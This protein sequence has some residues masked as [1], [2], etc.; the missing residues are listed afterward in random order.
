VGGIGGPSGGEDH[1]ELTPEE[2][3]EARIA[4]DAKLAQARAWE[5][6]ISDIVRE[7]VEANGGRL[8]RFGFRLKTMDSLYR[9]VQD[10]MVEDETTAADAA[11][12]IR[13]S[14]RYT[15]VVDESGYWERGNQICA[16]LA[17]TGYTPAKKTPGWRRF[18]YKGRNETFISSDGLEFEVQIHTA[19]SLGAAERAHTLYEE[20]RLP[21]T[22]REAK[23]Q[24][25]R[26]Q[27][28][29]FAAVPAPDDVRWVD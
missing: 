5:P 29:I 23:E 10:V 13:D 1:P 26:L 4:A 20:E 19:A 7:V 24:L 8:E 12:E 15:A 17:Q 6:A 22:S 25:R 11:G 2:R 9:K 14:L 27:D 28:E 3:F 16:A 18:G 21:T